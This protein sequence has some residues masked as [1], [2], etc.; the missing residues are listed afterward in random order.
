MNLLENVVARRPASAV[1]DAMQ[2]LTEID[3]LLPDTD[4]LKWFNHLYLAVTTAVR[5]AIATGSF[6]DAPW[7]S[8]LDV[9]FANLFFNALGMGAV[10]VS[11]APS[12]WRPVLAARQNPGLA[13]IQF[14]LA[15][16]NAHINRDLPVAI[17]QIYQANGGAPDRS[18]PHYADYEKINGILETVETQVKQEFT[19]GI[20]GVVDATAGPVDDVLAMWSVRAARDAAWTHAEVLWSLRDFPDLRNDFLAT[21]DDFTG[22]A[23]RGLL[24]HVASGRSI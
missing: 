16:M 8:Q 3:Q 19:T 20:I 15:G 18:D 9:I 23:G 1:A 17:V 14:A 21:L 24:T 4:G 12:A 7:L 6:N 2:M 5:D 10:D 11:A 13:K 22:F